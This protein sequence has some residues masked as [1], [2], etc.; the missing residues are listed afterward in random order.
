MS[1]LTPLFLALGLLAAPIIVLY[2][3]RLR[4][5]EILVSSTL[6]WQKLLRDREANAP[7]QRL[8]RNLLLLLQLLILAALVL[9]LARPF[10][11]V[12][13]VVSGSIVVLLDGSASMLATD[14]EPNRFEAA[15]KQVHSLIE[16]L[17]G[18][19][20]MTL[21]LVGR[22]PEVLVSATSDRNLLRSALDDAQVGPEIADWSS[23]VALAS[24]A[25]QGFQEARVL[26]VSDGG[27]P[28]GLPPLPAETIFIPIGAS[29]ENLAVTALASRETDS[30]PELFASITNYGQVQREA[31]ISI[32][33]DGTLAYSR[34]VI[35]PA[36][37][38][39]N[40]TWNVPPDT[41][42]IT[43]RLVENEEDYLQI[44]DVAWSIHEGIVS[45]RA[46]ILGKGNRFLETVFSVLPGVEVFRSGSDTV[47]GD[48]ND[49]DFDLYILDGVPV[50]DP[51]PAADL[52]II[53]PQPGSVE[54]AT[55]VVSLF[56]VTGIFSDTNVIRVSDSSLLRFVDWSN[57]H[58]RQAKIL[59]APWAEPLVIAEG[60]PLFLSGER[61]GRRIAI[62]P[63]PLQESDLPIQIA[64][65]ILMANITDWL[66][67]GKAFETSDGIQ[68]GDPVAITLGADSNAVI[69][70]KPNGER[71]L[72]TAG[73]VPIVFDKTGDLGVYEVSFRDA[74]GDVPAGSFAVNLLSP[75]E[76][77]LSPAETI[78]LGQATIEQA[79]E[80]DI[81]QREIWPWLAGLAF[82][83]LLI[84][85]WVFHRGTHMRLLPDRQTILSWF[86]RH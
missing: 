50:P 20:Q 18:G 12:P 63:F 49:G 21:I 19:D 57:I 67:P 64:F 68:P 60:G 27:L 42:L 6:L 33:L 59:D 11:P 65:P 74:T 75:G 15:K 10:L 9:A 61:N 26:V 55:E 78:K 62:L 37:G 72:E 28:E 47:L 43:A 13:S 54:Q 3:L 16:E 31:L 71:W 56:S 45:N 85:W 51:I 32:D 58:V 14:V 5:R 23:A 1:F 35:V 39:N 79:G 34:R 52:L 82:F 77:A 17:G 84:E 48:L 30:G 83:V 25:A 29:G 46:L 76:S 80:E 38:S 22:S 40:L 86:G 53:D 24:G 44:D 70:T 41:N 73:D 81:G 2:M 66:N 7:W 4:R 36:G 69:V 8:R